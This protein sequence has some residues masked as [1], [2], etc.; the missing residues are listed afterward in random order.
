M[1]DFSKVSGQPSLYPPIILQLND[2]KPN[3]MH[4]LANFNDKPDSFDK[5]KEHK[6][7]VFV[8]PN[9]KFE[10]ANRPPKEFENQ[11]LGAKYNPKE[12]KKFGEEALKWG[13][14][15][16]TGFEIY[17]TIDGYRERVSNNLEPKANI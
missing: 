4:R 8:D 14:R 1:V 16:W 7:G 11:T 12:V 15:V 3:N 13:K 2:N 9:D 10:M 5:K 17:D 6:R